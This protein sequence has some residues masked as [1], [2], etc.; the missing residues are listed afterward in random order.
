[1]IGYSP[2]PAEAVA[3]AK[4]GAI[5]DIA[6]SALE[7][8]A[9]SDLVIL[10]APPSA[11]LKL[12]S[13]LAP[14]IQSGATLVTD[15]SSVKGPIVDL[16]AQLGLGS[17]FAG[18]HPLCGTHKSGFAAA[19]SDLMRGAVV[20][21]SPVSQG[22]AVAGEVSDFWERVCGAMPVVMEAKQHDRLL[23]WTSHLPQA[24]A[25]ALAVALSQS[26]PKGASFGPGARDATRLAASSVE[27]WSDVM[28]LNREAVLEA[29][30]AFDGATDALRAALRGEDRESLAAWLEVGADFRK[31][32]DA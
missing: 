9:S 28:M 13:Q 8:A 20:Y 32:L 27:M 19:R 5:T 18:S 14:N 4:A 7:V 24:V 6:S 30:D 31:G 22:E 26:G 3:A 10:A 21:V 2:A 11:N 12:L 15:V 1:L 29:L 16:A 25:S 17:C 23:G